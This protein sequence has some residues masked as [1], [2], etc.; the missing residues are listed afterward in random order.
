[1]KKLPCII[2]LCIV[3]FSVSFTV[4]ATI[5]ETLDYPVD[6]LDKLNYRVNLFTN[7]IIGKPIES[8]DVND[9]GKIALCMHTSSEYVISIYDTNGYFLYGYF[10]NNE[11][12]I[13]IEWENENLLNICY[14][15]SDVMVTYDQNADCVS[16]KTIRNS[17]D[18]FL[19]MH[20]MISKTQ[21]TVDNNLYELKDRGFLR[22]VHG[23]LVK[24]NDRGEEITLYQSN[25]KPIIG[26]IFMI[27]LA[28]FVIG[29]VLLIIFYRFKTDRTLTG[30]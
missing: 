18:N 11:G 15:R 2:L 29:I 22:S 25:Q 12:S 21:Q 17:S 3:L 16:V 20:S 14:M 8:F 13:A 27:L 23:R 30:K 10:F 4:E 24:I 9:A 28:A 7:E 1:M 5:L 19:S 26:D 6:D